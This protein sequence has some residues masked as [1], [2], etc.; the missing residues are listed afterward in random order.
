MA[1]AD[2][3][4][5]GPGGEG[6]ARAPLA[7]GLGAAVLAISTAAPVIRLADPLGPEAVAC[8]RLSVT[9]LVL[10]LLTARATGRALTQ[11]ARAPREAWLTVT[12]LSRRG[13]TTCC[14]KRGK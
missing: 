1:S 9:V 8:L 7:L 5:P 12:I 4:A 11:L 10:G 13:A 2:R 6:G 3:G 14:M